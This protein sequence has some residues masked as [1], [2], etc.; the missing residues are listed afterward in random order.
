[1]PR[2]STSNIQPDENAAA[3]DGNVLQPVSNVVRNNATKVDG[4]VDVVVKNSAAARTPVFKMSTTRRQRRSNK[5]SGGQRLPSS[6]Y[7]MQMGQS[8]GDD[9]ELEDDQNAQEN[10]AE[11][12]RRE[13]FDPMLRGRRSGRK[14]PSNVG[15]DGEGFEDPSQFFKSPTAS[16]FGG[17]LSTDVE[18]TPG[19]Y[20]DTER[21]VSLDQSVVGGIS[22]T[23]RRSS[24]VAKD[25]SGVTR[26]RGLFQNDDKGSDRSDANLTDEAGALDGS[27]SI[28]KNSSLGKSSPSFQGQS[29]IEGRQENSIASPASNNHDSLDASAMTPQSVESESE[30]SS[31]NSNKSTSPSEQSSDQYDDDENDTSNTS[32]MN[33]DNG[34]VQSP[35][36]NNNDNDI[37]AYS[38]TETA[39]ARGN[40]EDTTFKRMRSAASAMPSPVREKG[41]R[42]SKRNRRAPIE[43]WKNERI[44]Y[45]R[46]TNE[47]M[48]A[49]MPVPVGVER[50][51]KSPPTKKKKTRK[52]RK[53]EIQ[54]PPNF[55]EEVP[56]VSIDLG[57]TTAD[58]ELVKNQDDLTFQTI[59]SNVDTTTTGTIQR[60]KNVDAAA[61]FVHD[62][63]RTGMVKLDVGA[64]KEVESSGDAAQM[65]CVHKAADKG[66]LVNI[67]NQTTTVGPG[68]MFLVPPNT[69][70]ELQNLSRKVG[71]EIFYTI[72]DV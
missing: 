7:L 22:P 18:S 14:K 44:V 39:G 33:D 13:A 61:A 12:Q 24:A 36:A 6:N 56:K 42:R 51:G 21:D 55:V 69:E 58:I 46:E 45:Q 50:L 35:S 19:G 63:I 37:S 2:T 68:C 9:E 72:V 15:L 16:G 43:W 53:E 52:S 25:D 62:S 28:G 38:P 59:S 8:K 65:F 57:D 31:P 30:S 10:L 47:G 4:G 66:L 5:R 23:S 26:R 20:T 67:N 64:T 54:L 34:L 27:V 48:E 60:Q 41:R 32:M 71:I 11:E 3:T 70:Y 40:R 29:P 49:V 1:M 17:R